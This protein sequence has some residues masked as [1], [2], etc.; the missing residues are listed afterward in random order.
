MAGCL[1]LCVSRQEGTDRLVSQILVSRYST[2]FFI[3]CWLR[4]PFLTFANRHKCFLIFSRTNL[5]T[6]Q[7]HLIETT[8]IIYWPDTSSFSIFRV[9]VWTWPLLHIRAQVWHSA[10]IAR[11]APIAGVA[12]TWLVYPYIKIWPTTCWKLHE[13][14][15]AFIARIDR[16]VDQVRFLRCTW[17][18]CT[19]ITWCTV[20]GCNKR[21]KLLLQ[22]GDDKR[23]EILL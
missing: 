15:L 6:V 12:L 7:F 8:Y 3:I 20:I 11:V 18:R 23:W 22:T 1:R 9:D 19:G 4:I 21:L 5:H 17:C 14:E 2:T 13:W 10:P 16:S